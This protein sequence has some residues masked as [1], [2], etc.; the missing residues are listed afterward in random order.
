MNDEAVPF[1]CILNIFVCSIERMEL[2]FFP[3]TGGDPTG[4]VCPPGMFKCAEGK[5]IPSL[6]VCNYQKDCERGE[7]E[8]QS[9]RKYFSF[10]NLSRNCP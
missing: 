3:F 4:V 2:I 6:W 1:Q 10:I 7:D 9:C 5:C 8:F